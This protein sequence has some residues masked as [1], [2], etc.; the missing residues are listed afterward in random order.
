M[1]NVVLACITCGWLFLGACANRHQSSTPSSDS[2]SNS[3]TTAVPF[4]P[5]ADLLGSEIRQVDST[6]L[7]IW[8]FVTEKGHKDSVLLKPA[9]FHA[10]A[11]QFVVPEFR[12][13]SF[14]KDFTES[15]FIDNATQD[16]TFTWST[17][18]GDLPL[19]RVDVIVTP[20]GAAHQ[21]KSVYL[22]RTRVSGDSTI[23]DKMFWQ[24]GKRFQI[25]SLI[26]IDHQSPVERQLT[27]IW[28]A[29][30]QNE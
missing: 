18:V 13:G 2:L 10:L 17:T 25:T 11:M 23:H 24:A 7:A 26:R 15:S 29:G 14:Q 22:E 9:E 21:M 6:P 3:D 28:D 8:K 19:Q 30:D 27:V 12:D 20:R 4:L 5:I 1:K 16:A